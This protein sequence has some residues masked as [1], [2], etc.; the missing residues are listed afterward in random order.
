MS[1]GGGPHGDKW[2]F[3][4]S[5]DTLSSDQVLQLLNDEADKGNTTVLFADCKDGE[6]A[7]FGNY[8]K[9]G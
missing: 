2:N 5:I 6:F 4:A 8:Q 1:S 3:K 7:F 9:S